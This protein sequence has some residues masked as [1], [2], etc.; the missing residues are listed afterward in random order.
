MG[1]ISIRCDSLFECLFHRQD[2]GCNESR[3][4]QSEAA[5]LQSD[6]PEVLTPSPVSSD[7]ESPSKEPK[8]IRVRWNTYFLEDALLE[9][10]NWRSDPPSDFYL[11]DDLE[12]G[13]KWADCCHVVVYIRFHNLD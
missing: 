4:T 10:L 1:M 13:V 8:K 11:I 2:G 7:N 6:G 12:K 5:P 3:H 9:E